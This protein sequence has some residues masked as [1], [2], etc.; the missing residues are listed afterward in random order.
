MKAIN[1]SAAVENIPKQWSN[2]DLRSWY[3]LYSVASLLHPLLIA[4]KG[5]EHSQ[6]SISQERTYW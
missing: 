5:D 1:F 6:L 4:M 3:I 2:V